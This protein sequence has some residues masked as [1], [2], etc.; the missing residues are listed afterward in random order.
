MCGIAG[1]FHFNDAAPIGQEMTEMLQS[2]R[3]RG[4]D[5]T[6]FALY[7]K[8]Q[9]DNTFAIRLKLAEQEDLARGFE[10]HDQIKTRKLEVEKRIKELGGTIASSQEAT[11]YAYLYRVDYDG[12]LRKLA[13]YLEDIENVEILSIGKALELVKDLGDAHQVS[14]A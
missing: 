8:T 6:G 14:Q 9:K 13:D 5:S 10:I 1:I 2:M 11:P 3:H 12:D 7:A 4:A